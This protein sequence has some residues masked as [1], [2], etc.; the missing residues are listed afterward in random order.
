MIETRWEVADLNLFFYDE[1]NNW[2][3]AFR[4]YK[5]LFDKPLLSILKNRVIAALK[6]YFEENGIEITEY[7][8]DDILIG[9]KSNE[10]D[11]IVLIKL[12]QL[13]STYEELL[14]SNKVFTREDISK[15]S[16]QLGYNS[17]LTF[18]WKQVIT[19]DKRA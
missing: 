3:F 2:E 18:A 16:L 17:W 19:I 13:F 11:S 14:N 15:I 1:E 5:P 12:S 8:G 4:I 9:V 6:V 7:N 10:N